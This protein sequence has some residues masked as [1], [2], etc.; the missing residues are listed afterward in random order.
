MGAIVLY[1]LLT[2]LIFLILK[3]RLEHGNLESFIN[4]LG[5][6]YQYRH[7][8][9]G[10]KRCKWSKAWINVKASFDDKGHLICKKVY[11]GLLSKFKTEVS[12]IN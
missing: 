5:G 9:N 2:L 3:S 8:M 12:F 7:M 4:V 10:L 6:K 1:K 11:P